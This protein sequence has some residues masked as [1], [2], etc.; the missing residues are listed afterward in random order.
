MREAFADQ[1]AELETRIENELDH[2]AVTLAAIGKALAGDSDQQA[3]LTAEDARQLRD[4]SRSI[5][6]DLV[7]VTARQA[8]VAGDLRLVLALIQLAHHGTLIANQLELI[9][10]QLTAID[11]NVL[12]RQQTATKLTQMTELAGEQLHNAVTA[13]ASRDLAQAQ[14]IDRQDDAIDR[15]NRQVF[16]AT[17]EL[18]A[19][20]DQRELALRHVLIARSLERVGDNAVDIAEQAAFLITAELHEFSDA[21]KPKTPRTSTPGN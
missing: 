14:Q 1:L 18:D 20:P 4:I 9:S 8:P 17:L 15:L 2:T 13:F 10:E 7:V 12:D 16:E 19:A 3:A 5:D 6:T 11:P 21:S